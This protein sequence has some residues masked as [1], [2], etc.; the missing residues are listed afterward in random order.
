MVTKVKA[1]LILLISFFALWF[2]CGTK[3]GPMDISFGKGQKWQS[4]AAAKRREIMSKIPKEWL[5][6]DNVL[7]EGKERK[8]IAGEFI[9][10]LLDSKTL[11]ITCLDNE[12]LLELMSSGYLSA[13][14]VISAFCKRAAYA[15]QLVRVSFPLFDILQYTALMICR[16]RI[17]LR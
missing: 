9:E 17:C 14:E 16:I 7:A 5:R 13:T 15:H 2:A 11:N 3:S 8:Q 1:V 6:S 12:E 4:I 10:R